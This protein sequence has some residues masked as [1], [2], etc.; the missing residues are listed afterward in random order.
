MLNIQYSILNVQVRREPKG[1][2][3]S[4]SSLGHWIL[5]VGYWILVLALALALLTPALAAESAKQGACHALLVSG[6]P[7][8]PIYAK[9]YADWQKRF[10]A[11][12][13][14]TAKVPAENI[15]ILSGDEVLKDPL[16]SGKATRESI[17]KAIA[18]LAK[19]VQPEDQFVL[20]LV[21]HGAVAQ[22]IPSFILPGQDLNAQELADALAAIRAR[23]QVVL[24]FTASSGD[25][26]RFLARAGRV[27]LAATSPTEVT[28]PVLAE[29][30]LRGIESLR[31]DGEGA[32]AAGARDGTVTL[33]EASN[34]ASHQ[35]AMWITRQKSTEGGWKIDGKESV[36]IFRKLYVGPEGEPATRKLSPDSDAAAPDEAVA[37][38]PE[39]GLTE[40]WLSRRIVAE[41]ATLE[42]CGQEKGVSPLTE[43]GYKPI[44]G[45]KE[46]EPGSLARRVVLGK[47]ALLKGA[48]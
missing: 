39:G 3:R 35:A 23:N 18:D 2:S 5:G 8:A 26:V 31:A 1:V 20:I 32:P 38:R 22:T 40:F 45:A 12:L 47:P 29:F 36:E 41:H 37:L 4:S 27:V 33:L 28:E 46:G 48:E 42:D 9:R 34:W 24:S 21:G 16:V 14:K 10:H 44:A 15:A 43:S 11:Y 13:T 19:K 25:F 30:F 7:G 6:L 17:A